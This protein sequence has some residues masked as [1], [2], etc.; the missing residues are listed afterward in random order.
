M[1]VEIQ[2]RESSLGQA[3][4][5]Y[6]QSQLFTLCVPATVPGLYVDHLDTAP[7][8][9]I[10]ADRRGG[11][12]EI[13]L[14]V[15]IYVVFKP[16]VEAH[17][18][19]EPVGATNVFGNHVD[20]AVR[21]DRYTGKHIRTDLS[22]TLFLSEPSDYDGGELVIEDNFGAQSIKLP[23]GDLI[24]YPASSVHHVRPVTRGARLASFFWIQ[25]MVR[26]D[27]E[28]TL[29]FD[30]DMEVQRLSTDLPEHSSVMNLTS[31]Y[32]NLLRRWADV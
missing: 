4:T 9:L 20:N 8:S 2:I 1:T 25:S 28:R 21:T 16:D 19:G 27:G 18:N 13:S 22:A 31:L 14:K 10:F 17:P 5:E 32:H 23:A 3:V 12:I 24:L 26:D 30:L 6:V 11:G 29:L 15:N 7:G